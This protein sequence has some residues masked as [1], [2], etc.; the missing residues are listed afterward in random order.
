M[1]SL[2]SVLKSHLK[3][4]SVNLSDQ[5]AKRHFLVY[6]LISVKRDMGYALIARSFNVSSIKG[7]RIEALNL[8]PGEEPYYPPYD[9]K[10]LV[11]NRSAKS[12]WF[13]KW[14]WL[15]YDAARDKV[16]CL[17]CSKAHKQKL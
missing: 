4:H 17:F 5:F 10:F 2:I 14:P 11:T 12:D 15:H 16:F 6:S 13:Q 7:L 1:T 9:Y 3:I 8:G